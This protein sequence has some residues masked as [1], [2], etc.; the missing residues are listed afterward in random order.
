MNASDRPY[1][2]LARR[3]LDTNTKFRLW[4]DHI[5]DGVNEVGRYL[6]VE[7]LI[8][9]EAGTSGVAVLPVVD[10][11]LFL[12]RVWRH[13]RD[14]WGWEVP[15]GFMD[16]A[17]PLATSALREL[18]EETGLVCAP[19]RLVSLGLISQEPGVI[20]STVEVFAAL[21]CT[22]SGPIATDEIGLGQGRLFDPD[23]VERMIGGP[24]L[25]DATT[26]VAYYRWR[27]LA[28][29][30]GVV[31]R[32]RESEDRA[33]RAQARAQERLLDVI[34]SIPE[35]FTLFDADDRL[36]VCNARFREFHPLIAD[37]AVPGARFEDLLRVGAARGQFADVRDGA[38]AWIAE[39]LA[40]HRTPSQPFEMR[41]ADGRV[42][43]VSE[44][45]TGDGGLVAVRTDITRVKE[46]EQHLL[47]VQKMEALGQLTGGIA[48]DF[49]N[50]LTV[51]LANIEFVDERMAD[52]DP[53]KMLLT[54]AMEAI[55]RGADLTGRLL[56]FSRRQQQRP[57][58]LD[59]A[60]VVSGTVEMLRR[61]IE[62]TI[63][64]ATR[65]DPDLPPVLA[66]RGQLE[67][68]L[69]NLAVNARDA[70]TSGGTL[71]FDVTT[72][73][74]GGED[75][76]SHAGPHVEIAVTDTGAGMPPEVAA[77]AAEP[78]FTTKLAGSGSGLGLSMVYGFT[79]QL[80]GDL[81]IDSTPGRGTTVRLFLPSAMK[82]VGT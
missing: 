48:H 28:A 58:R 74:L 7:P 79:R 23:A 26:I 56:A 19:D 76:P 5:D 78:F 11:R 4:F 61:T 37:I 24:D 77:R 8:R 50:I 72:R 52:D 20:A 27:A 81:R 67:N 10:G 1:R 46:T 70:M 43:L 38:E 25:Y 15:R 65:F 42:L 55:R 33:T 62:S 12:V 53:S 9:T 36:V 54:R 13:P 14:A 34:E 68:A 17:E 31:P 80:G 6:V 41:L 29:G 71:T 49:N 73:L 32:L 51:V 45:R 59:V 3:P 60:E 40:R 44:R 64:I 82:S 35:A 16:P 30:E 22:P 75:G 18:A 63:A 21:D 57:A 69:V 47:Q 66:E 2:L 39:R